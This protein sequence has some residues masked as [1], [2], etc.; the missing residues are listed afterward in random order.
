MHTSLWD[1]FILQIS[2]SF[3]HS[4]PCGCFLS[5]SY[6]MPLRVPKPL[7]LSGE[8]SDLI[9]S[10]K[11][12]VKSQAEFTST[13]RSAIDEISD[14]TKAMKLEIAA[15]RDIVMKIAAPHSAVPLPVPLTGVSSIVS[16]LSPQEIAMSAALRV[17]SQRLTLENKSRRMV[18]MRLPEQATESQTS[19]QGNQTVEQ[20][21]KELDMPDFSRA[22][23]DGKVSHHRH[24][25][26]RN[27]TRDYAKH[28]RPLKIDL[29]DPHLRNSVLHQLR[30]TR[31]PALRY[32]RL[33]CRRDLS[34]DE[35]NLE[36]A[37]RKKAHEMKGRFN[38]VWHERLRHHHVLKASSIR[39]APHKPLGKPAVRWC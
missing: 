9:L 2:V 33:F 6:S 20:I 16:H 32:D 15:L 19:T 25:R 21:V 3:I 17:E 18:I 39:E 37:N 30:T 11:E 8:L 10:I 38:H 12:L 13:I 34:E 1:G 31:I 28:P 27:P 23:T 26:E 35:L 4:P 24:P 7:P 5:F 36:R 22:F 29:S 14:Q